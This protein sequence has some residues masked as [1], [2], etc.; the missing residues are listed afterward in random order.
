MNLKTGEPLW[1]AIGP[2][3]PQFPSLD[4]DLHCEV[5]VVGAGVSG[6]M[7]AAALAEAG[8]DTVVLD[9][10]GPACGSTSA[11]SAL[12]LYEIDLPLIQLRQKI[13]T[14]HANRAYRAARR[15]LDD[16]AQMIERFEISCDFHRR[17]SLFLAS[18]LRDM[19]WFPEEVQ[20]RREIGIE[21]RLVGS[22]ESKDSFGLHRPGAIASS[23]AIEVDP[24]RLTL[25]L[26]EVAAARGARVFSKTEVRVSPNDL[27]AGGRRH[28]LHAAHGSCV[29]CDH[30]IIAT[31]YEAPEQFHHLRNLCTLKST[32]VLASRPIAGP[33][34]WPDSLLLWETANPYLY[35]RLA[36]S[37]VILGGEDEP[38]ADENQRD[39]L[40][41]AK[42]QR[43]LEK[44]D[45]LC[46]GVKLEPEFVWAA[47]FAETRDG[48][49]FIG[50][51][52][53]SNGCLFALGYGGNGITWSVLASQI[54]RDQ[55]LGIEN[56]DANLFRF[57]R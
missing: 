26:I 2:S 11:S 3:P 38:T 53:D 15:A 37:R 8:V 57:D 19:E 12:V 18:E 35:A 29:Q 39:A 9:R 50:P 16:L 30:V 52:P 5:A 45:M 54:L 44:F 21:T 42:I 34:P 56:P 13:G 32:Y 4:A 1:P 25:G 55:I 24:Y 43:L 14:D 46:P 40:I 31:G 48:L 41:D 47:A 7:I 49:P 17:D 36:G 22:A 27:T 23:A 6:A 20:A 28:V 51:S 10:R 33:A